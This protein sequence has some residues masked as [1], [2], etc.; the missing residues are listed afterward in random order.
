MSYKSFAT[1]V[2]SALG[3]PEVGSKVT[4]TG[5]GFAADWWKNGFGSLTKGGA[6]SV[7]LG[8]SQPFK[9]NT[10]TLPATP[11]GPDSFGYDRREENKNRTTSI[12]NEAIA[13]GTST[14]LPMLGAGF[15]TSAAMSKVVSVGDTMKS[16]ISSPTGQIRPLFWVGL[17]ASVGYV[18]Y[19]KYFSKAY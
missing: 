5:N 11:A 10:P 3:M 14:T 8:M 1:A 15:S 17:A 4:E 7:Q 16:V 18:A 12:R 2:G 19:K 9:P 13:N 6:M